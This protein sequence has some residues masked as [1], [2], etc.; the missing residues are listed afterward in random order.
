MVLRNAGILPHHYTLPQ[1]REHRRGLV[2][3]YVT[4]VKGTKGAVERIVSN[5]KSASI[6]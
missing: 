2:L 5:I 1:P 4:E 6:Y 3:M